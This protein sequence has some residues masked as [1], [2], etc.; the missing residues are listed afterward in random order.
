MN[1]EEI[2]KQRR[3][4]RLLP[5]PGGEVVRALLDEIERLQSQPTESDMTFCHVADI[6]LNKAFVIPE[7]G[8]VYIRFNPPRWDGQIPCLQVSPNVTFEYLLNTLRVCP[9]DLD[10]KWS[11]V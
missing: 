9:I 5:P 3:C 10:I 11:Y 2:G 8:E 4:S 7:I 6:G 1:K